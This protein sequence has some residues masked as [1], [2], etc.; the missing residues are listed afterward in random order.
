[1]SKSAALLLA[2]VFLTASCLMVAKPAFS[3]AAVAEDSWVSKAP[4]HVA[5]S[6]L[7]VAVMNGKIY[8]IGGSTEN[9]LV[10]INEEY[11]PETNTWT[12]KKPMP[13][14]RA[15]FRLE[16][17]QNKI[18]CLGGDTDNATKTLANEV[19]DPATD[20][21]ENRAPLPTPRESFITVVL[22]NRIYVIGGI[23]GR[24]LAKESLGAYTGATEVYDPALDTWETK[25]SMLN[26][27]FP[28]TCVVI[29][30]KIYVISGSTVYPESVSFTAVYDEDTDS[31]TSRAP[32]PVVKI[33]AGVVF[34]DKIYFVGGSY[35]D[36]VYVTLLQ[37]YD[38]L[39]DT[40]SAGARPPAE[41]VS[42]GS[43]FV[44]SGEMAPIRIYVV[45]DPLRIYD[46]KEDVWTLGPSKPINRGFM[47]VTV[48]NDK[49]YAIGGLTSVFLG[50]NEPFG[51]D[52]TRYATNEVYTPVGYGM[53]D[54]FYVLTTTPPEMSLLSPLNQTYYN[55]SVPLVFTL[56]KPVV[57]MVYSLDGQENVTLTGN[58]TLSELANG[59]HN[60]TVYAKDEFENTGASETISFSVEVPFPTT[61]V[62]V[63]ST[64]SVAAIGVGLLVYFRRRK[65]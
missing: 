4:M 60:I 61:L 26:A 30:G 46:P 50:V 9:G 62:A 8:A 27:R 59:L 23:K 5:R 10:G 25:A 48:L 57:W 7:G 20:T 29:N 18:Y 12:Y 47:G 39:T 38:T 42:I 28:E 44:T 43:A 41:G 24:D 14:P 54:S 34:D 37:I 53:S 33:G 17:V 63:A 65:R 32:M 19:Y 55:S 51:F 22:R 52:V 2:L 36:S 49:I 6:G 31:W 64:A 56:N 3:S 35:E 16:V 45:E 58:T 13:T 1:M 21:W 11:D 40:W 15:N